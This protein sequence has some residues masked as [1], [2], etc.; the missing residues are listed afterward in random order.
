MWQAPCAAGIASVKESL[1]SDDSNCRND[2]GQIMNVWVVPK[3]FEL[4]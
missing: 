3:D 1:T 4:K 2:P